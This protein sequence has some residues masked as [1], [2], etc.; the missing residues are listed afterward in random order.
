MDEVFTHRSYLNEAGKGTQ[1]NERLEFLGDSI[2]SFI[3]SSYIFRNYP[4]LKEGELTNLRSVLTNTQTL[5]R[6]SK[7]LGIGKYLKLSK[8]EEESGG[9]ESVTILADTLEALIGGL[10][11]DQGIDKAYDFVEEILL[12]N[13]DNIMK[14]EELKD[15]KSRLQE[16]IQEKHKISPTYKILKE[17][18]PDHLKLYTVGVYL[19]DKLLAT[20][21]GRSKQEA[22]KGAAKIALEGFKVDSRSEK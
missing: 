22:E 9:R 15:P 3:V 17:E 20:G 19:S 4:N 12:K 16:I 13:I 5:Y 11:M 2:L 8:G 6:I 7:D 14:I 10:Y 18:G 1:S 21:T